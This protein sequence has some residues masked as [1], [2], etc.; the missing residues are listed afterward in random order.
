VT[1]ASLKRARQSRLASK[2]GQRRAALINLA[3][4]RLTEGTVA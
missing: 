2:M 4:H 1:S 3:I